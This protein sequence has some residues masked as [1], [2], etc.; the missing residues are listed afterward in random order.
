MKKRFLS[1][2]LSLALLL[3][4]LGGLAGAVDYPE[5]EHLPV[6]YADMVY[7]GFDDDALQAAFGELMGMDASG[8]LEREQ[9]AFWVRTRVEELYR[10]ILREY[11]RLETQ[12]YLIDLRRDADV[13]DQWAAAESAD[14][15]D[16]FNYTSD[17]CRSALAL[18]ADSP[19][20]D[21]LERDAGKDKVKALLYYEPMTEEEAELYRREE[22]LVQQYEAIMTQE[23]TVTDDRGREWTAAELYYDTSLSNE[24]YYDLLT[25]LEQSENEA[26]GPIF[27]ELVALRTQLARL[28]GYDSYA[29]YAYTEIYN[30][31]YTLNEIREVYRQVKKELVPLYE[32]ILDRARDDIYGLEDLP[33]STGEEILN[34]LE[35]YMAKV[36]PELGETFRFMRQQHLYDIEAAPNKNGVG[37]TIALPA[38]GSA[39]IFNS[40]HGGYQDWSTVIHEFGHFNET[41]HTA[42]SDLWSDFSIDVGEIH[43]QG[44]EVLFIEYAQDLFGDKGKG[45]G[46]NT[47]L[48]MVDS[49]LDG[50]LYD[51]FQAMIYDDPD[52]TLDEMNVLF[53]R[54]S[55]EYGYADRG[56]GAAYF[57]V[58][59][60]HNF[61]Q[62][63]YYISYATSALSAIDLYLASLE[64]REG[65]VETYMELSALGMS[66]PYKAAVKKVGLRNIFRTGTV[67][68]LADGLA[69]QLKRAYPRPSD[70]RVPR[71]ETPSSPPVRA[72]LLLAL[73]PVTV[74]VIVFIFV[75]ISLSRKRRARRQSV[76][77]LTSAGPWKG[78]NKDPWD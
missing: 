5:K 15:S 36:H 32:Q 56:K 59:V 44:L 62:P 10:T 31:D 6:D 75:G 35:P 72:F 39:F 11:D 33:A 7:T 78:G 18:I 47:L 21:I 64:D 63:M 76:D 55:Q 24:A 34:E 52:M 45:F 40:P 71:K 77:D 25:R 68:K 2:L 27:L 20:A 41:F 42:G 67:E 66:L 29:E 19:Y 12:Y 26:V 4:T 30:R 17:Q 14:F 60:P 46:W 38:Y 23:F 61:Q 69:A 53:D 13:T 22:E 49:V 48:G 28:Y 54:L 8:A 73:V 43:S 74:L 65:A 1:L 51:E 70:G 9:D 3:P 50:C 37:Y 57:W 58:E 16:R